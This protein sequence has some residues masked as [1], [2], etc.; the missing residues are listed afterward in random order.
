MPLP[1][2]LHVHM[3]SPCVSVFCG[4]GQQLAQP[5]H[6]PAVGIWQLIVGLAFCNAKEDSQIL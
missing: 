1:E 5:I 6:P 3:A 4:E 2:L